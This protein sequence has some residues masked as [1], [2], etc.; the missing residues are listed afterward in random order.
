MNRREKAEFII[1]KGNKLFVWI[2][3]GVLVIIGYNVFTVA[4]DMQ[5]SVEGGYYSYT[6]MTLSYLLGIVAPMTLGSLL[7][8][9][10]E[11]VGMM[12]YKLVNQT[13]KQWGVFKI[14]LLIKLIMVFVI[15]LNIVG[16]ALDIYKGTMDGGYQINSCL[17]IKRFAIV[18]FIWFFWGCICF[19]MALLLKSSGFSLIIALCIYFG[20]QYIGQYIKVPWGILWNQKGIEYHFFN[21][22]NIPFGV[23]QSTYNNFYFSIIYMILMLLAC[24]IIIFSYLKVKYPKK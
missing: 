4:T 3:M 8:G 6:M 15:S 18:I 1:L 9:T 16:I 23:V 5:T 2:I 22:Q 11:N 14:T 17:L 10:D 7:G 24:L 20:E 21:N 12:E 19:T 13:A